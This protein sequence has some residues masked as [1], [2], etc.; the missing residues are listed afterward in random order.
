[1]EM[2]IWPHIIIM[3]NDGENGVFEGSYLMAD[4]YLVKN[5]AICSHTVD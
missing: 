2:C 1:M 5:F 4:K 3:K